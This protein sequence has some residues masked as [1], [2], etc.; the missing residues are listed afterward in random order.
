[1]RKIFKSISALKKEL[2]KIRTDNGPVVLANGC[3]DVIHAGHVRYLEE[4]AGLGE[5]LVVAVNNDDS[6]RSLKGAGRP[7][8][9]E[10][11][12]AEIIAALRAV[13]Y[14]L[15]FG[16]ATVDNILLELRPDI[17][18][19][20]T[21]YTPEKVPEKKTA[22]SIGCRTVITGDPKDHSSRD[23]IDSIAGRDRF[24]SV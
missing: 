15:I 20:G 16:D 18:A 22:E 23:I 24:G 6:T 19:K 3:F 14:V 12:R 8:F 5:L 13:D 2:E 10:E 1:L 9:P 11:E 4:A 21:D 17:H 7:V